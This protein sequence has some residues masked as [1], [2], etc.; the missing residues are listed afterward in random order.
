VI[1]TSPEDS[2]TLPDAKNVVR[3]KYPST[4]LITK[5]EDG[6]SKLEYAVQPDAGG[7]VPGYIMNKYVHAGAAAGRAGGVGRR[8]GRR[9]SRTAAR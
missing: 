7:N 3:A 2:D 4:L 9:S 5:I 1:V 6:L 8:R